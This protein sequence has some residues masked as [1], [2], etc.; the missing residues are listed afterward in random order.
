MKYRFF[1]RLKIQENQW[2]LMGDN[3]IIAWDIRDLIKASSGWFIINKETVGLAFTLVPILQKGI[4]ELTQSPQI[5][6]N[7]EIL[8]GLGTIENTLKFY[9]D[10][11][12]DC[13]QYPYTELCGCVNS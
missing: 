2:V 6:A 10:L 5:Y 12:E 7:Y 11:L 13:Q 8:H 3:H 4:L 9:H 1:L